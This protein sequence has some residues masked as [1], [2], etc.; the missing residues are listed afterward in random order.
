MRQIDEVTGLIVHTAYQ[1][2]RDLGPGLLESIYEALMAAALAKQGLT[3]QRQ[4]IVGFEYM[5]IRFERAC[6]IDLLVDGRVIV[7]VKSLPALTKLH[8]KQLLTYLRI[9][10]LQVG[11]LINLGAPEFRDGVR[12]LVNHYSA[13][14][15]PLPLPPGV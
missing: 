6:K 11:L 12:R 10:N 13:R 14:S 8:R 2:H 3:V 9:T 5:G 7:E 15:T 1:I 4:V